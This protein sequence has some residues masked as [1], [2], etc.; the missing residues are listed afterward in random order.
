M[1]LR[2]RTGRIGS[3]PVRMAERDAPHITAADL[4]S[5]LAPSG[6]ARRRPTGLLSAEPPAAGWDWDTELS[7]AD[8]A[9]L[10]DLRRTVGEQCAALDSLRG[11]VQ[12][13]RSDAAAARDGLAALA[14]ARP[15][16]RRGV[17]ARLRE[18]DLL[19]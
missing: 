3:E 11:E 1:D 15:W 5:A 9:E 10:D 4:R 13:A 14:A 2:G 7:A 16:Q 12:T 19:A 6:Q 18:R 17:I 8:R